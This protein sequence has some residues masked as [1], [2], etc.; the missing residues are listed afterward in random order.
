MMHELFRD[1]NFDSN[2]NVSQRAYV[3]AWIVN[4]GRVSDQPHRYAT[5]L[6]VLDRKRYPVVCD[7]IDGNV[8]HSRHTIKHIY[9]QASKQIVRN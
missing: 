5:V 7:G 9:G 6:H 2:A 1:V 3:A 4:G 8:L